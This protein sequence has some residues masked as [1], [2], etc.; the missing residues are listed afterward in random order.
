MAV[1]YLAFMESM[2]NFPHFWD[3][4]LS[5]LMEL[6]QPHGVEIMQLV[7][8][9][10]LCIDLGMPSKKKVHMDGHCPNLIFPPPPLEN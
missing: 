10:S 9:E 3:G 6:H 5:S 1:L 4:W 2:H 7:G 8:I